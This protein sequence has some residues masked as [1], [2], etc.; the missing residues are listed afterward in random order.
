MSGIAPESVGYELRLHHGRENAPTR[1]RRLLVEG[2]VHVK[3]V[4]RRGVLAD[5]RG[6]SGE[7]RTVTYE[8]GLWA[9]D[10]PAR[11]SCAHVLAV[12]Q[13]VVVNGVSHAER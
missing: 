3:R 5:V 11:R 13:V 9:C 7:I 1:A 8:H 6:D 4:D 10:C 2:R 12:Q